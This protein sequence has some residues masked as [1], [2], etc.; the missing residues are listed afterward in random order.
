MSIRTAESTVT[1]KHP[2]SLQAF[3]GK[4]PAGDYRLVTVEREIVGLSFLAYRRMLTML[5]IPALSNIDGKHHVFHTNAR[6]LESAFRADARIDGRF[7]KDRDPL[8][9]PSESLRRTSS[10]AVL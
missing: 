9:Q 8:L 4:Q 3:E 6:E 7:Q 10:T 1:F 2:F 5:H